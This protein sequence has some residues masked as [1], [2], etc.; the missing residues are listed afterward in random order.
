MLLGGAGS[1]LTRRARR[2][3]DQVDPG[4]LDRGTSGTSTTSEVLTVPLAAAPP[5][6]TPAV[7]ESG[8][9]QRTYPVGFGTNRVLLA[10]VVALTQHGR[11]PQHS[12]PCWHALDPRPEA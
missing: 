8:A 1:T 9:R 5:R 7:G 12:R 6:G 3:F 2:P 10:I 11:Q 4:R